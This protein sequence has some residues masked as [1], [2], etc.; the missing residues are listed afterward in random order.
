MRSDIEHLVADVLRQSGQLAVARYC[1]AILVPQSAVAGGSDAELVSAVVDFANWAAEEAMLVP[2]EFPIEALC[3]YNVDFFFARIQIGGHA[4]WACDC[5]FMPLIVKLTACGL[6]A[7]GADDYLAIF[8]QFLRLMEDQAFAQ[9]IMASGDALEF[10]VSQEEDLN[11]LAWALDPGG[12]NQTQQKLNAQWLRSLPQ[13][14]GLEP[15]PLAAAKAAVIS[16]NPN[17][18]ERRARAVD[19]RQSA[20]FDRVPRTLCA[21]AGVAL[22]TV[23]GWGGI[24]VDGKRHSAWFMPTD[25]G[26]LA[27]VLFPGSLLSGPKARLYRIDPRPPG[28]R[29]V[30]ATGGALAEVAISKNELTA[31]APPSF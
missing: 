4:E 7:I 11:E 20:F 27:I 16:A 15:A 22:Y 14:R 29:G 13:L 9:K 30:I 24:E 19:L 1:D 12:R 21:K 6:E 28:P 10:R 2:G 5:K 25:G 23:T 8:Q 3:V 18:T 26:A 31:H 17:F